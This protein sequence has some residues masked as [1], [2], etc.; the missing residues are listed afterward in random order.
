[1]AGAAWLQHSGWRYLN[2]WRRVAVGR[3][4]G[5]LDGWSGC[6]R[7]WLEGGGRRMVVWLAGWGL[8]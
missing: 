6:W 2:G 4:A 1:M 5:E 7:W 3:V 8:V